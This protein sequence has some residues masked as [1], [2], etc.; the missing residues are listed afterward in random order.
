MESYTDEQWPAKW[1]GY[2]DI[3]ITDIANRNFQGINIQYKHVKSHQKETVAGKSFPSQ[4]NEMADVLATQ[5]QR[6]ARHPK[7]D[8]TISHKHLKIND[9]VVTKDQQRMLMEA[10]SRIP[11]QQYYRDKYNWSSHTFNNIHWDLQ[12]K[13]LS[14]YD[15]NDQRRILKFV[16]NWLPTNKRL[17]REK[18]STTQRCPLCQYI[19]EDE[20]HM[21]QCRHAVQQG[22]IQKLQEQIHNDLKIT[23]KV[24]AITA[25]IIPAGVQGGNWSAAS[26]IS[27]STSELR[28]GI[29]AQSQ[30][31]WY[32][33]IYGRLAKDFVACLATTAESSSPKASAEMHGRKLIRA[34]WDAMLILWKQ[35]N[36][37][38][39]GTTKEA[40]KAAQSRALDLKVR[41]C[42]EQQHI[43]PIDDRQRLFQKTEDEKLREDP[44]H[45]QTWIRMAEKIIRTNKR[46]NKRMTGQKKMMEQY[47]KWNPPDLR[48]SRQH[49][50]HHQ[51]RKNDLKPD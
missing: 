3:D 9:M 29:K 14:S 32:Q 35:R 36:K 21:F 43:M 30:I 25:Q 17:H 13:V 44:R 47:F 46:E 18:A 20:L 19:V 28:K 45:I 27:A 24:K 16:H 5:Q 22:V 1:E 26:S 34:I 11:L 4:L 37:A 42:Y 7:Y 8:V 12:Y 6:I 2:P 15:I 48:T 40:R 10:A 23:D 38:V 31:G 39:H 49:K 41:Y 50:E 33:I 51:H